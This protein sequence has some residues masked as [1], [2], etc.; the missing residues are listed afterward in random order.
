MIKE[1]LETPI[2]PDL[3]Y[4]D[5]TKSIE[6]LT[7]AVRQLDNRMV[8]MEKLFE[9]QGQINGKLLENMNQML[10]QQADILEEGSPKAPGLILPDRLTN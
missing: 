2:D 7:E 4:F 1:D 3:E 6:A 5:A 10:L 8:A 9:L